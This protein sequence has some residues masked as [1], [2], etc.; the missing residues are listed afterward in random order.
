MKE[1]L[2][3]WINFSKDVHPSCAAGADLL[4]SLRA[5]T[6]AVIE[7]FYTPYICNMKK[8]KTIFKN[9]FFSIEGI[10][11]EKQSEIFY[12]STAIDRLKMEMF[13]AF[14]I[15]QIVEWLFNRLK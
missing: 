13:K 2:I 14:R 1:L 15:Q 12:F 8:K 11:R 10:E 7:D 9:R 5:R 3:E 4:Q 6:E